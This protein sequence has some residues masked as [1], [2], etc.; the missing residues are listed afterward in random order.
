[1]GASLGVVLVGLRVGA[2]DLAG[3]RHHRRLDRVHEVD[4]IRHALRGRAGADAGGALLAALD[5]SGR[6]AGVGLGVCEAADRGPAQRGAAQQDGDA[7]E[8]DGAVGHD[9]LHEQ[10][11]TVIKATNLNV[12]L[13][14]R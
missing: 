3:D 1:M 11:C 10:E 6:L 9:S 8:A 2:L 13:W 4:E 12:A 14:R 5:R 7:G